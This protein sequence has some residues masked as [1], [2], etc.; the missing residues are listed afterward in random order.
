MGQVLVFGHT[1]PDNDSICS[2]IAYAHLK[3]LTDPANVYVPAR[4]GPVPPESAWVLAHFGVETPVEIAHVRIRVSDVMTTDV[5]TVGPDDTLATV[6][7]LLSERGVRALPVVKDG[8][9]L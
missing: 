1:S 8:Q 4:L 2:A 7:V 9:V 6:G 3:N 5:L